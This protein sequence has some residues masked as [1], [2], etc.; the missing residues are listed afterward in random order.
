MRL[1][2]LILAGAALLAAGCA[3]PPVGPPPLTP[4]ATGAEMTLAK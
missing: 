4:S 2:H 1:A 3:T